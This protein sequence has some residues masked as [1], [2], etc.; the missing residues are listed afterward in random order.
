[1]LTNETLHPDV[2]VAA[3]IKCDQL[4][5]ELFLSE[6]VNLCPIEAE[7]TRIAKR[8]K[9]FVVILSAIIIVAVVT[10]V[11]IGGTALVRTIRNDQ[12]INNL[13]DLT[14]RQNKMLNRLQNQ[15][16]LH[17][18]AMKQLEEALAKLA[19]NVYKHEE[20]FN[21]FKE[22]STGTIYTISYIMSR[23]QIGNKLIKE[24]KRQWDRNKFNAAFLDY[25]NFT[26]PCTG[27]CP[28]DLMK[29]TSSKTNEQGTKIFMRFSV[30][31]INDTVHV[32]KADP[33]KLMVRTSTNKTC[34]IIYNC[35]QTVIYSERENCIY[36]INTQYRSSSDMVLIPNSGCSSGGIMPN[37]TKYYA[38]D[39]CGPRHPGDEYDF[40]GFKHYIN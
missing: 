28:Y 29:P 2:V 33:F 30:P 11:G 10:S 9:R 40:I 24:T 6:I 27:K 1:M 4:Y 3:R 8:T 37:T 13:Q 21:L 23:L 32:L 16:D 19:K 36:P 39:F 34:S 14:K 38:R 20:D 25:I 7:Q 26:L 22:R 31:R 15:V 12:E 35:P 17:G 18:V 5:E